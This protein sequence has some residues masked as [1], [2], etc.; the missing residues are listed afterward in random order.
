M[1]NVFIYYIGYVTPNSVNSLY[2]IINNA[3]GYIE[4]KNDGNKYLA[5]ILAYK[6]KNT[7]K[8]HEEIWST[9]KDLIRLRS[10]NSDDSDEK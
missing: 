1:K 5:L 8:K 7:L 2:L 4:E 6:I 10:N 3:T 9:T